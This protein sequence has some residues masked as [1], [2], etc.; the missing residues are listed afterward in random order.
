MYC[1][2][3][4]ICAKGFLLR[5]EYLLIRT[6]IEEERRIGCVEIGLGMSKCIQ[7][8]NNANEVRGKLEKLLWHIR[9]SIN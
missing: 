3:C 7:R 1:C 9:T 5:Q 4:C 2:C 8:R 6:K